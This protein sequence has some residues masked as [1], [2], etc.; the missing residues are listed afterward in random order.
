MTDTLPCAKQTRPSTPFFQ[1]PPQYGRIISECLIQTVSD[2]DD[3]ITDASRD[4]ADGPSFVDVLSAFDDHGKNESD[5]TSNDDVLNDTDMSIEI[6]TADGQYLDETHMIQTLT[7]ALPPSGAAR[8]QVDQR[9]RR[10]YHKIKIQ[11]Y[12]S[13]TFKWTT[14]V[15]HPLQTSCDA[16]DAAICW[17]VDQMGH[18]SQHLPS[19][20]PLM[21]VLCPQHLTTTHSPHGDGTSQLHS[22]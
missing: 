2:I 16:Q 1:V 3:T 7:V 9:E 11:N 22:L 14:N 10:G 12:H 20:R 19:P 6:A 18:T 5:V 13:A 15:I 8:S 21:I 4:P 17:Q